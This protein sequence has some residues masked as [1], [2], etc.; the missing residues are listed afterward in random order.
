M[1]PFN[2]STAILSSFHGSTKFQSFLLSAS[3]QSFLSKS[4]YKSAYVALPSLRYR[5]NTMFYLSNYHT[6]NLILIHP[7]KHN[8]RVFVMILECCMQN[9]GFPKSMYPYRID[10][11]W[12]KRDNFYKMYHFEILLFIYLSR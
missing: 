1:Y 2:P 12:K 5:L 11:R 10:F 3:F 4:L 8:A 7:L 9:I 6:I